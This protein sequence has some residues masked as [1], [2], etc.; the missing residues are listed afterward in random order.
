[1]PLMINNN[2]FIKEERGNGTK[3]VSLS[4]KM[5]KY[6]DVD[7]KNWD[8]KLVDNFSALHV[9]CMLC[10]TIKENGNKIPK[11]LNWSLINLP[12]QLL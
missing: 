6:C 8:G 1:M 11:H 5:K 7:C 2:E 10:E 4:V 9:E 12:Q 3:H